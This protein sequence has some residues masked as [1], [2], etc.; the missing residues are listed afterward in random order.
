MFFI[1]KSRFLKGLY[2]EIM[3]FYKEIM[4]FLGKSSPCMA[5]QFRLVNYFNISNVG[6][7]A[8]WI[9]LNVGKNTWRLD[10]KRPKKIVDSNGLYIENIETYAIYSIKN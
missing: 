2:K 3:G 1:G 6:M 10:E 5:E 7:M 9:L 4:F 8:C